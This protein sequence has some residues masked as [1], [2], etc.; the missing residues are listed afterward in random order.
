VSPYGS[1]PVRSAA[2]SLLRRLIPLEYQ[3]PTV[4]PTTRLL[5][6]IGYFRLRTWVG[7]RGQHVVDA[8]LY[9]PLYSPWLGE[10]E[11]ESVYRLAQPLTLVSRQRCYVLWRTLLQA[12][13]LGGDAIECGVFRGGTALL[14]AA[15]IARSGVETPLHLVD[16][17]QGMPATQDGAE[18]F[19]EGDF[20][21]TSLDA[22]RRVLRP[23][24]FVAIHP[25]FIPDVLDL[26]PAEHV[27]WA[28]VDVDLHRSVSDCLEFL[29]PRLLP[30]AFVIVDDYA[31]P[32]CPGARAAVDEFFA[33]RPEMPMCL[34]TGQCLVVKL[35]RA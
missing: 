35:G 23:F 7:A 9:R 14:A 3:P 4:S 24:P 21:E 22:V 34:P 19:R 31:F 32:S 28:H 25:G 12:L 33:A 1:Q 26:V 29:Y 15:T 2:G 5:T 17:F 8:H 13:H 11:F 27:A 6:A 30:G 20:G 18:S 10:A 16:S